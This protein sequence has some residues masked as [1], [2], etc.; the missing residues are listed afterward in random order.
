MRVSCKLKTCFFFPQE[1]YSYERLLTSFEWNWCCTVITMPNWKGLKS[2][3]T[4]SNFMSDQ[5]F[6]AASTD[7]LLAQLIYT[8]KHRNEIC[9]TTECGKI[10]K[11]THQA[12]NLN[13]CRSKSWVIGIDQQV[14]QAATEI[15]LFFATVVWKSH[16]T[17]KLEYLLTPVAYPLETNPLGSKCSVVWRLERI[18][19]WVEPFFFFYK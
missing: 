9:L 10:E 7:R 12:R 3:M 15:L 5:G 6:A 11:H 8:I 13:T 16:C 19:M 18:D 17:W 4:W 2:F 1:I 14:F